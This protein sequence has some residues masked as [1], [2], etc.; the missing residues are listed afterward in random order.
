M[1]DIT[2]DNWQLG[3]YLACLRHEGIT[4]AEELAQIDFTTMEF[5]SYGENYEA[6]MLGCDTCGWGETDANMQATLTWKD[7]N[8]SDRAL[9]WRGEED[10]S[11]LINSFTVV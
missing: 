6:G 5:S 8:G 2:E 1:T 7:K 10:V 4:T 11:D 9:V 3:L